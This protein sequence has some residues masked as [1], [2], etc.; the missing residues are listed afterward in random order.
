MDGSQGKQR[1]FVIVDPVTPGGLQ[2]TLGFLKSLPR[3][4]VCLSRAQD[5]LL[6][7]G[8]I[9]MAGSEDTHRLNSAQSMSCCELESTYIN[10]QSRNGTILNISSVFTILQSYK[11]ADTGSLSRKRIKIVYDKAPFQAVGEAPDILMQLRHEEQHE[12]TRGNP[13]AS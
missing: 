3:L 13:H 10:Q 7:I 12:T 5:G 11:S 1:G 4:D 8:D 6:V 2:Y 9:D